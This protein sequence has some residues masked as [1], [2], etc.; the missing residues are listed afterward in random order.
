[1]DAFLESIRVSD[2]SF[3][4]AFLHAA[5]ELKNVEREY[6]MLKR[7]QRLM[8][9][10]TSAR[11]GSDPI[12]TAIIRTV[13]APLE[14]AAQP[15]RVPR[16]PLFPFPMEP[17]GGTAAILNPLRDVIWRPAGPRKLRRC[18]THR[19]QRRFENPMINTV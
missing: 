2:A 19:R 12:S 11:G 14:A 9:N 10:P 8:F 5:R 16:I 17:A 1:M 3:R 6:L 18:N 13:P 7:R 4:S 15:P